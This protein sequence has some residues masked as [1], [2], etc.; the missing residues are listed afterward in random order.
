MGNTLA[1][2]KETASKLN[3]VSQ[4]IQSMAEAY[5]VKTESVIEES[6]EEDKNTFISELLNNL[7]NIKEN[8]LYEDLIKTEGKIVNDC[9]K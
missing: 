7:D 1:Q 4:T 8:M 5:N 2:G 6:R 9:R 3:V